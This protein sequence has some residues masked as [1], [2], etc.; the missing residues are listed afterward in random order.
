MKTQLESIKKTDTPQPRLEEGDKVRVVVKKKFEKGFVPDWS[1]EVYTVQSVSQGT[2][3][4]ALIHIPDGPLI[5]RRAMSSLA[6]PNNT[7]TDSK[8]G[9]Y[10]RNELLLVQKA[11][12]TL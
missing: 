2:D 12:Y 6:D 11:N 4:E 5:E 7:L 1:D 9:T 3:N 8:I 10:T